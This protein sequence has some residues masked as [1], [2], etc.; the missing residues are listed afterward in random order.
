M[1]KNNFDF[2]D[3]LLKIMNY[4]PMLI[5]G[6]VIYLVYQLSQK[7]L[8]GSLS[9][10]IFGKA[11]DVNLGNG[12][13]PIF[14]SLGGFKITNEHAQNLSDMLFRAMNYEFGTDLVV[15]DEVYS[16]LKDNPIATQQVNKKF[17]LKEYGKTGTPWIPKSGTDS[18]LF[19]WLDYELTGKQWEKWKK[20]MNAAGIV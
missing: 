5:I 3:T 14:T 8:L 4:L 17:G 16:N 18:T 9:D 19:E 1:K 15:M 20:V 12:D 6:V 10:L 13:L 11:K 2:N 7:G